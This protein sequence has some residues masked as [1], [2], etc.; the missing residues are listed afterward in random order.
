MKAL[1]S[2][3]RFVVFIIIIIIFLHVQIGPVF[4][5]WK[6]IGVTFICCPKSS[7]NRT[8][9]YIVFLFSFILYVFV[10]DVN[11]YFLQA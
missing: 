11:N 1:I 7:Q 6:Q 8:S 9:L 2:R 5:E 3:F 10:V 4:M